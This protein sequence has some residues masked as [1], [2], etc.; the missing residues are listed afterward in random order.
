MCPGLADVTLAFT[1]DETKNGNGFFLTWDIDSV[2]AEQTETP[3]PPQCHGSVTNVVTDSSWWSYLGLGSAGTLSSATNGWWSSMFAGQ[4]S[5]TGNIALCFLLL[6]H[7]NDSNIN[8]H[9][10]K[11]ACDFWSALQCQSCVLAAAFS[12]IE[13]DAL[14]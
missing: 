14:G 1:T 12:M 9:H 7:P 8:M 2:P 10:Y 3:P 4:S 6:K 5:I 13:V 11:V